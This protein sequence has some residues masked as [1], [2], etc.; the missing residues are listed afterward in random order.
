M[1]PFVFF[2]ALASTTVAQAIDYDPRRPDELR[3]CDDSYYRGRD[4]EAREC[5][6][7]LLNGPYNS[8]T[9]AEAAWRIG[10]LQ[11]ANRFFREAVRSNQ[12]L[13]HARVRWARLYLSTHQYADAQ[14]L[15]G[16]ALELSPNDVYGRLALAQVYADR[17]DGEAQR[18]IEALLQE[19]D[20]LFEAHLLAARMALEA[21]RLDDA[22]RSLDRAAK[23]AD[24][25]LP[26]LELYSAR[27]TLDL[28]RGRDSAAMLKDPWVMRALN[29]NAHYGAVFESLAR[30]EV[31]RRRYAEATPLL[32]KAIEVQPTLWSAHADLGANLLRFGEIDAARVHLQKAYEGDP[33]SPTTVNTLRLLDR[34]NEIEVTSTRFALP[35]TAT[36]PAAEVE[37]RLRLNTR[38]AA[39]LQPYV[40][41][42]ARDSIVAFSRRYGYRPTRPLTVELYPNHDDFA[43]R[44]AALP[45]IGLLGVTFGDLVVMDSPSGRATGDF[46]WGTTLWHEMAHVF[47]L[48]MTDNRIPRWLSEGISVFEEWRTGPTPGVVITPDVIVAMREQRLLP[49]A[50]LDAGFIRPQYPNQ[51]QVSYAQAGLVCL[52]IEQRWG[53]EQLPALV[54]QFERET[55]A[56]EAIENTLKV[57]A[58]TFDREFQAF[59]QQRYAGVLNRF[60]EWRR[61][62]QAASKAIEAERWEDAI[63]AARTAIEIHPEDVADD[64]AY[65]LLALASDKSG[66]RNEA[67]DA[68][69]RYRRLG[70]WEPA[71]LRQ[72]AGWLVQANRTA[73]ATEVLAAVNYA[74]PLDAVQHRQLGEQWLAAGRPEE[75]LREFQVLLAL[76]S[77]DPATAH[78]GM[79]RALRAQG[80]LVASR[81]HLLDSLET[82]PH[83]KPAQALL[84]QMIEERK[85]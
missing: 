39:A 43:V 45:G 24:S 30:F 62:A 26:L 72:L 11:R 65:L 50:D 58:E 2:L 41:E 25:K 17:F 12:R 85:E 22:D 14:K 67:I 31:M 32:R 27:A 35:S 38:E 75:S 73:E 56:R 15:L 84:L 76:D 33:Y 6:V 48:S 10:D 19:D 18:L 8:V 66:R 9:R 36:A 82:A 34:V 74:D 54:R 4:A 16:E 57:P 68:L 77:H 52:F 7:R 78:F 55:T 60:D 63:G 23:A 81:R 71:A 70:G 3:A 37:L 64:S 20:G 69:L 51:V 61:A 5:Y 49:I 1:R 79:A 42:I 47:T 80:D 46:H 53:F 13:I 28:A 59:L 29:Y 21:G 83:Y 40:M 44:V